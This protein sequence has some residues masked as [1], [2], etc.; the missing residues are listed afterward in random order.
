MARVRRC[1][2][3]IR[4]LETLNFARA[5]DWLTYGGRLSISLAMETMGISSNRKYL[6][7]KVPQ[8][9]STGT[10]GELVA[11]KNA[12]P[13]PMIIGP[14]LKLSS[15]RLPALVGTFPTVMD[16]CGAE[17]NSVIICRRVFAES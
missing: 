11:I 3:K 10:E 9:F 5:P 2:G 16:G 1:G 14:K 12:L 7:F 6:P 17:I 15:S 13:F 4:F 8:C